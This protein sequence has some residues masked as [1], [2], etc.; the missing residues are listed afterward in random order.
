MED[1]DF[2]NLRFECLNDFN[3]TWCDS[4][5][6]IIERQ[7]SGETVSG[8]LSG[9]D[10]L[11]CGA[12]IE[13]SSAVPVS[14]LLELFKV[15]KESQKAFVKQLMSAYPVI[16]LNIES[17]F[18]V[19]IWQGGIFLDELSSYTQA[20][21]DREEREESVVS[22]QETKAS[23]REV[24]PTQ[25]ISN[26]KV[27]C[28]PLVE[29]FPNLINS[30]TNYIKLHKYSAHAQRRTSTGTGTGVSVEDVRQHLLTPIPG[31]AE[32]GISAT[33]VAYLKGS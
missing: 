1:P 33:S 26:R 9:S 27:G 7:N 25:S 32:E 16:Y 10:L 31:L 11:L 5:E 29:K 15:K 2:R 14:V 6:S 28:K 20:K 8:P 30:A 3:L 24:A 12:H 4:F 17:P 13:D 23:T 18:I 21:S 19:N 22:L